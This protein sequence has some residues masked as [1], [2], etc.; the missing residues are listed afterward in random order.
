MTSDWALPDVDLGVLPTFDLAGL[1]VLQLLDLTSPL[2]P[3]DTS[4]CL[5]DV[6][7]EIHDSFFPGYEH[8]ADEWRAWWRSGEYPVPDV[9][10]HVILILR[11]GEPVGQIVFDTNVRRGISLVHY[12][13]VTPTGRA[14]LPRGWLRHAARAF[15]D[16]GKA[17]A[18]GAGRALLG[19]AGEVPAAHVHKWTATGYA[20]LGVDYGE[21]RHGMHW[22][23]FGEPDLM[24]MSPIL[25]TPLAGRALPHSH[26]ADA[27]LRAFLIDHYRMDPNFPATAAVLA[28][29]AELGPVPIEIADRAEF[30]ECA[31]PALLT[32]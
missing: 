26:V 2:L 17:D 12:F 22:R 8:V 19:V 30:T 31:P 7:S 3:Q 4:S 15:L 5:L 14:G 1:P 23:E 6:V 11:D 20:P 25:F 28:Q 16:L 18:A 10:G 9:V 27:A 13:A 29:A 21:P 32:A 24:S